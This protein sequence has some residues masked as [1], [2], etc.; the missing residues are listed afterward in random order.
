MSRSEE[1]FEKASRL[2]PGGVNSPVRAFGAVGGHPFF[3]RRAQGP[4]LYDED[5]RRYLDYVCSWGPCI[6]GHACPPVIE[7]VQKACADGLTFGAPTQKEGILAEMICACVPDVEMVR[8]VSSGTEAVMSAVRLARGFTGREKIIKFAGNYHGHSDGL[9]VKAG[10][11]MMTQSVPDSAGVP[12]GY[13]KTTLTAVYNDPDSVRRLM[14]ENRGEVAAV[15]VE[16]VAANMGVVP[17]E[18]GFLEFLRAITEENG[19]LLVFDEVITGFRLGLGGATE[20]TGVH[21]DLHTFGKIVGGGMP[22]AA[23]GGSEKIMSCVAPLGPVYQA[24]TLSGNPAAVTAGIATLKIL[25][26]R[27]Q[28]YR[29]L[30]EKA[31]R[32]ERAFLEKGL[33]VNRAGSLL[34]PF[35]TGGR[36]VKNYDGALRC[37]RR[38]FAD[39]FAWMLSQ[40]IYVAPSP[41]EAMFVSAAHSDGLI[42]ETCRAIGEWRADA[43]RD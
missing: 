27:P 6:L 15:V 4:W 18:P 30:D 25:M 5:G 1:L 37:D 42:E 33:T 28:L 40:D 23:Y 17:P 14:E 26:D 43:G 13:A 39:Y 8:L 11:G 24:G 3:V 32:L 9:L 12:E 19:A 36:E 20:Y 31:A 38:A 21:A 10:S 7:A 34:T 35:F 2:M 16:P 41:F 29:E 22:L